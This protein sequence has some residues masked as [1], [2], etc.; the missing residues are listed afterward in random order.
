MNWIII[1]DNHIGNIVVVSYDYPLGNDDP[2]PSNSHI[3]MIPIGCRFMIH[4][5]LGKVDLIHCNNIAL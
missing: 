3:G 4:S 1:M 5:E 2:I